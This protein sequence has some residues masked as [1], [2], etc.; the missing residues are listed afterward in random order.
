MGASTFTTKALPIIPTKRYRVL[1][2]WTASTTSHSLTY[3]VV[4]LDSA[5]AVVDTWDV[6]VK[7][8]TTVDAFQIDTITVIPPPTARFASLRI[9]KGANSTKF[10]VART[11][12]K[13]YSNSVERL[14]RSI[15]M[16]DDFIGTNGSD[17]SL[18][19]VKTDIAGGV[20]ASKV[21]AGVGA[22]GNWSEFGVVKLATAA[23]D[24]DGGMLRLGPEARE[25]PPIGLEF[26]CKVKINDADK[27]EC[28]IGFWNSLTLYPDVA[29]VNSV[30][31]IGLRADSDNSANWFGVT[32]SGG[33]ETNQALS[34]SFHNVWRELGFF[35]T[36]AGVFFTVDG[37]IVG[38]EKTTNLPPG[39]AVLYPMIAILTNEASA[40]EIEIDYFTAQVH[41]NRT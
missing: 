17:M 36:D 18:P 28:W 9:L 30:S 35:M 4:W 33:N 39:T 24:G 15:T 37:R 21:T 1:I 19:W 22:I 2:E 7:T 25:R 26:R 40:K 16:H 12:M 13:E 14:S 3:R 27:V 34:V 41:L 8:V 38:T 10:A 32:R 6:F 11:E 23:T 5:K 31:G 20:T 29:K